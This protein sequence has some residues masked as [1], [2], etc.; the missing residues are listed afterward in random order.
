MAGKSHF[1]VVAIHS[2]SVVAHSNQFHSAL[3][4]FYPAHFRSGIQTIFNKFFYNRRG[5][6]NNF[7]RGNLA[8]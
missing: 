2:A 1:C 7:A 3:F 6:F 5:S 8:D 4:N